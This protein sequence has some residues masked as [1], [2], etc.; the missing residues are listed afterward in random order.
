MRFLG[1]GLSDRVSDAKT[2]WLFRE[3]LTQAGAIERLFERFEVVVRNTGYLPMSGQILD[4]TLG[5]APKQRNINGEKED[6]QKGR[7]PKD[8]Q[9]RPTK[10]SHKL[11]YKTSFN[12]SSIPPRYFIHKINK[13]LFLVILRCIIRNF[14]YECA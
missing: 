12:G 8:G 2:V 13:F 10:L 11:A 3:C 9:D 5:A 6:L 7:L 4:A 1:S 14:L